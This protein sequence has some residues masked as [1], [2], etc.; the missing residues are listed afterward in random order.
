MCHTFN[1][2][3]D[4]NRKPFHCNEWNQ[5]VTCC[6]APALSRAAVGVTHVS[7]TR[8]ILAEVPGVLESV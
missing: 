3:R 8:Q 7:G 6:L 2:N 5:S 4:V 1:Y